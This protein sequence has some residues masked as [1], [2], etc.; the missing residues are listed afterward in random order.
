MAQRVI[1]TQ[2]DYALLEQ[3]IKSNNIKKIFLICGKSSYKLPAGNFFSLIE[4][5]GIIELCRFE[6]FQPNPTYESVNKGVQA[7]LQS[8]ADCIVAIGG[9]SAIDVAKCIK[10][11]ATLDQNIDYLQQNIVDNEIPFVVVP[12]T[13]GTGSEATHFAVIYRDGEKISVAHNSIIPDLV[14]M[15]PDNLKTL[16]LYQRQATMMDALCHA[17]EACWSVNA[18]HESDDYASNAIRLVM[19]YKDEYLNNSNTGNAMMLKAAYYAGKAINITKTTA[20]HAM[21]YKLTSL[22]NIAHGHAVA[23]CL[24]VVWEH[25]IKESGRMNDKENLQKIVKAMGCNN[26]IQA[27]QLFREIVKKNK[28][29]L[30]QK[31]DE[32]ILEKLAKS[33][34]IERLN[35]HPISLDGEEL[36]CLYRQIFV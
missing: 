5:E 7:F 28:F 19:Q 21:S 10:S 3:Y 26:S 23:I 27:L 12:T 22:Y 17:I 18:I 24:S 11:F 2:S 8:G 6:E 31:I 36:K 34:N 35:N 16:P 4:D 9:G 13:A 29:D 1:E 30:H 33:V 14:I 32:E 25:L 20:A 15:D